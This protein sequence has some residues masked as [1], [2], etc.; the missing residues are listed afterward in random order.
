MYRVSIESIVSIAGDFHELVIFERIVRDKINVNTVWY[1]GVQKI[2]ITV[3]IVDNIACDS[4]VY[5]LYTSGANLI[6][7]G[8][9]NI[10]A[11]IAQNDGINVVNYTARLTDRITATM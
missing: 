7:P 5:I 4:S 11:Y 8:R 10:E 2:P 9:C 1:A 3:W 6:T